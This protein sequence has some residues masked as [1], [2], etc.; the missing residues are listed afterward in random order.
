MLK[1]LW[2]T[3]TPSLAEEKLDNKPIGGGWIKSLDYEMQN[4][5]D[6]HISFYYYKNIAPFKYG[7]T[8]YYP[9]LNNRQ[10]IIKKILYER[11][12]RIKLTENINKLLEIVYLIKPDLIHIHG[13]EN[14]FG[15]IINKVSVPVVISIQGNITVYQHKFFSGFNNKQLKT[16]ENSFNYL[17][18]YFPFRSQYNRF[19]RIKERE[20]KVL[21]N[22]KHI[23][24]RTSWDRRIC[25]IFAPNAEYFHNDEIL[26]DKFYK[27]KW[28]YNK[29]TTIKIFTTNGNIFHKGFETLCKSVTLLKKSGLINFQWYVAGVTENDLIVKAAKNLLGNDFP[30]SNL[31]LLGKLSEDEIINQLLSSDIYVMTSHIENSPNN[32]CEA[33][34]L[35]MPCIATF[36]GGTNTLLDDNVDG[37]LIQNGDPWVMAGAIKELVNNPELAVKYGSNARE[38]A[39]KRHDKNKISKSLLNIYYK[40]V[41]QDFNN[42]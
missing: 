19:Q 2:F 15:C 17:L 20:Q 31:I 16:A 22:T 28:I 12:G 24:G 13:T 7:K 27:H 23:I 14:P 39:L 4:K 29:N 9:I 41:N 40:I 11:F 10:S 30:K 38:K 32:L 37:I 34:I 36:A 18:G 8:T 21:L 25:S 6:L 26:R 5:V 33:M 3:N 42:Q 1:V 35:G